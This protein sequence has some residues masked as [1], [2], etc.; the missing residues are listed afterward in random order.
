[1]FANEISCLGLLEDCDFLLQHLGIYSPDIGEIN[2][3]VT[4][5]GVCTL[6]ARGLQT[7][8]NRKKKKVKERGVMTRYIFP[9][10]WKT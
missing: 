1:M 7:F 9:L 8:T 10:Q 3:T 4:V 2:I 5:M 6:I